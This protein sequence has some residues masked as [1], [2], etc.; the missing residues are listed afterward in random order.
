[1]YVK[2]PAKKKGLIDKF[3]NTARDGDGDCKRT[4]FL[5]LGLSPWYGTI[6]LF[7]EQIAPSPVAPAC[8]YCEDFCVC[9]EGEMTSVI[10]E[11]T[12]SLLAHLT[13]SWDSLL[14]LTGDTNID[15]QKPSDKLTK[16]YRSILEA[17]GCY[18]HL[19]NQLASR[20]LQKRSSI[21]LLLTI[22]PA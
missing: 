15:M 5:L 19:L 22:G 10:I 21:T 14:F 1:M 13:V 17:L 2:T 3:L 12:E 9:R 7:L 18:Q 16:Q 4:L 20:V 11:I 6:F 8:T